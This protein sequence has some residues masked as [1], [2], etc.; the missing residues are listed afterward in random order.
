MEKNGDNI[1]RERLKNES[2]ESA[3]FV[4]CNKLLANFFLFSFDLDLT[5]P[6]QNTNDPAASSLLM[7]ACWTA[8]FKPDNRHPEPRPYREDFQRAI[9]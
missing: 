2:W 4:K 3:S 9:L 6:T 8:G 5:M 7:D 1:E